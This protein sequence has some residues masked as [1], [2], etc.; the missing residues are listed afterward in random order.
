MTLSAYAQ[1]G[2]VFGDVKNADRDFDVHEKDIH[3]IIVDGEKRFSPGIVKNSLSWIR[4]EDTLLLPRVLAKVESKIPAE[5]LRL[6]YQGT[7]HLFQQE[8]EKAVSRFYGSPYEG[9]KAALFLDGKQVATL[10]F[11]L[12]EE[13]SNLIIDY[14]CW[15]YD[16][17]TTG[18]EGER[19][20]IGCKESITGEQ[21]S[22]EVTLQ[23][24]WS[25]PDWKP[26][27]V[28]EG[29][30]LANIR[31]NYPA[32]IELYNDKGEKKTLTI[33][34]NVPK[35]RKRIGVALGFGPYHFLSETNGE[36]FD[37][38]AQLMYM[39]YGRYT[40]SEKNSIKLFD[41]YIK[42]ESAFNNLGVYFSTDIAKIWDKR[43]V[44]NTLIGFQDLLFETPEVNQHQIIYPQGLEMT[45]SHPFGW[46][47][48]K[49][50]LGG[51]VSPDA[52]LDYNNVW[53]RFGKGVFY[54]LNYIKWAA[55]GSA[56]ES[57]GLSVGIPL[58]SAF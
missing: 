5:K 2:Q 33:K 31:A 14:A 12:P 4:A 56:T 35:R 10:E 17:K 50:M 15:K 44:F 3:L 16:L 43:L 21:G 13:K 49:V 7:D 30:R 58:F 8:G 11:Q 46:K 23:V 47:N 26:K 28:A 22:E 34:A 32:K 1:Y 52:A 39:L 53:V 42:R 38:H 55:E 18:L 51:F 41:A 6:R 9:E 57:Y 20:S 40:L 45:L 36:Q 19:I 24:L 27:G 54:E 25:S 48:Y 37:D 29:R